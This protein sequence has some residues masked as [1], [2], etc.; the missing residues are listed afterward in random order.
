MASRVSPM[1]VAHCCY[2]VDPLKPLHL[3]VTEKWVVP[4][5]ELW[6]R[7]WNVEK[8]KKSIL[9]TENNV[10]IAWSLPSNIWC[11]FTNFKTLWKEL[12]YVKILMQ[13]TIEHQW[14]KQLNSTGKKREW[15]KWSCY[16][17]WQ[18]SL[19]NE[20][21]L[22]YQQKVTYQE[23][24]LLTNPKYK[25]TKGWLFIH[26]F[27]FFSSNCHVTSQA[28]WDNLFFQS[29]QRNGHQ[30][31]RRGEIFVQCVQDIVISISIK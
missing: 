22:L 7:T 11:L 20:W 13:S 16:Y 28:N 8:R 21:A 9:F 12:N 2:L 30:E 15:T 27:Y 19:S 4:Q 31:Q 17:I 6:Q 26:V 23:V 14:Q 24:F 5:V 29:F 10:H 25:K 1:L 3:T 18:S